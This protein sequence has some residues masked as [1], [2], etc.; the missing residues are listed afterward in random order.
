MRELVLRGRLRKCW[1][2]VVNVVWWLVWGLLWFRGPAGGV[3]RGLAWV[4]VV[5]SPWPAAVKET[6]HGY[7]VLCDF[8]E[9]FD[10]AYQRGDEL[11]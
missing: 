7:E 9:N 3:G 6:V 5:T 4:A 8:V 2:L 11:E 1:I 10:Y